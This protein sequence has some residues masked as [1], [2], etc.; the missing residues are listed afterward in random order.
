MADGGE[1]H[2]RRQNIEVGPLQDLGGNWND[3]GKWWGEMTNLTG[4]PQLFRGQF[5]QLT[6]WAGV[7]CTLRERIRGFYDRLRQR[8]SSPVHVVWMQLDLNGLPNHLVHVSGFGGQILGVLELMLCSAM[9]DL[10]R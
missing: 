3:A 7:L 10:S 1:V 6:P 4:G 5:G 8:P 2:S 9:A